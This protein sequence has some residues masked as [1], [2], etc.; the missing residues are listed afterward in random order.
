MPFYLGKDKMW[1]KTMKYICK[2]PDQKGYSGYISI[3]DTIA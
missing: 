1:K 2:K 3:Q